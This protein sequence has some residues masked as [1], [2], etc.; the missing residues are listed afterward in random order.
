MEEPKS[1][2]KISY[3]IS[4]QN[5]Q[6]KTLGKLVQASHDKKMK[7]E[8]KQPVRPKQAVAPLINPALA[9]LSS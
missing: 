1:D 9:M 5:I 8:E 2:K 7:E 4:T 3:Q 6:N